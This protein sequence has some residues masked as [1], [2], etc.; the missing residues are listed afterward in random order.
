MTFTP[1]MTLPG[2][3]TLDVHLPFVQ[4]HPLAS[5]KKLADLILQQ[6]KFCAFGGYP[7]QVVLILGFYF[8]VVLETWIYVVV[9]N[10]RITKLLKIEKE[11]I[12]LIAVIQLL[13]HLLI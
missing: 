12:V 13:T 7:S 3:Y 5:L 10:Q 2:V 1:R 8:Y 4:V 6:L 11:W 9:V